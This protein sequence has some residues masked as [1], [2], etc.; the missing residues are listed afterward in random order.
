[1]AADTTQTARAPIRPSPYQGEVR[2]GSLRSRQNPPPSPSGANLAAVTKNLEPPREAATNLEF[3]KAAR[4]RDEV[5][6][7][8][9]ME[10][11][12]LTGEVN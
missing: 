5:K 2:W 8:R 6:R 1:I 3:E 10:L 7:L 9:E 4:L 11:D 12:T